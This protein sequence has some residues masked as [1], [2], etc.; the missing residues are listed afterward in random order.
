M[1][2]ALL[3]A[4]ILTP[5]LGVRL[6]CPVCASRYHYYKTARRYQNR[7]H[8]FTAERALFRAL[9]RDGLIHFV[10]GNADAIHT[11]V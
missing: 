4:R 6:P 9:D 10:D 1:L 5:S 8:S 3:P 2:A 7:T 11:W